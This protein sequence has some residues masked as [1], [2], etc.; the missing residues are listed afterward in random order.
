MLERHWTEG[1]TLRGGVGLWRGT[2]SCRQT[3]RRYLVD[4]MFADMLRGSVDSPTTRDGAARAASA[5]TR[6]SDQKVALRTKIVKREAEFSPGAKHSAC[7]TSFQPWNFRLLRINDSAKQA[8]SKVPE[9]TLGFWFVKILATTL[10]ETGGDAVTMSLN[11]GY[12]VGT[13]IFVTVFLV[14]VGAQIAAK[15][16]HPFLLWAVI[17]P[18]PRRAARWPICSTGRSE[19]ATSGDRRSSSSCSWRRSASGTGRS[20]PCRWIRPSR[21]R[22]RWLSRQAAGPRR[23]RAEPL[24]RLGSACRGDHGVHRL[25]AASGRSAS[26]LAR[27]TRT[28]RGAN[29]PACHRFDGSQTG[30]PCASGTARSIIRCTR[31][32]ATISCDQPTRSAS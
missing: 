4:A 8:L 12:L 17:T 2:R 10:G 15:R 20:D 26:V 19:S 23:P 31:Q 28:K 18:Q 1:S 9:V 24:C 5:A 30:A 32:N 14:A 25:L 16:F 13:A 21:R 22:Q 29:R 11:L 3:L 27:A 7:A 6:T